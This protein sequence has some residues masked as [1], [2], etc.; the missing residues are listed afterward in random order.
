MGHVPVRSSAV[1]AEKVGAWG[2]KG[3][4]R[5]GA[6][7]LARASVAQRLLNVRQ[8]VIRVNPWWVFRIHCIAQE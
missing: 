8:R 5:K 1:H 6:A 3:H 4:A 7:D 2:D